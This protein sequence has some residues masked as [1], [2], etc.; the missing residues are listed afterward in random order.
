M[1]WVGAEPSLYGKKP[2]QSI[3]RD[4]KPESNMKNLAIVTMELHPLT[5]GEIGRG[6]RNMLTA[7]PEIDLPELSLFWSAM[8]SV[9]RSSVQDFLMCASKTLTTLQ[10]FR[11]PSATRRSCL[12][13]YD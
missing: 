6:V 13:E 2:Y 11:S 12:Q 10:K 7:M 1:N 8:L 3:Y 9:R 5:A 4:S